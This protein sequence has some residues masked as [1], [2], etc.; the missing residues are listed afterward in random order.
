V[1]IQAGT[2]AAR[3][4]RECINTEEK[5]GIA[6]QCRTAIGLIAVIETIVIGEFRNGTLVVR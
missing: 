3:E 5:G 4:S 2:H 1:E 6:V